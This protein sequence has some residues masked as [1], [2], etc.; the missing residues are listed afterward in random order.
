MSLF[1]SL[2]GSLFGSLS[3]PNTDAQSELQCRHKQGVTLIK[4]KDNNK[5][6]VPRMEIS[7]D[8]PE[9]KKQQQEHRYRTG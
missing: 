2:C 5:T 1:G 8:G 7:L 4:N 3:K 9:F 6:K